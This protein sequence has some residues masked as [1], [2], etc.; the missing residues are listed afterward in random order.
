MGLGHQ[1]A[2]SI[3]SASGGL[4]GFFH[5]SLCNAADRHGI[6]SDEDTRWYLVQLLCNYASSGH[7]FDDA[8]EG[9]RLTPLAE[10]YRHAVEAGNEQ[11]RRLHLQRLGDVALVIAGL[12]SGVLRRKPVGVDYYI[13]MGGGAYGT[14]A[15]ADA[16]TTRDRA[17]AGIF[18]QLARSFEE[19]VVV[20]SDIP[21]ATEERSLV[22]QLDDWEATRHP[23]IARRLRERGVFV[24]DFD[25]AR[26]HGARH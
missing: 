10:H 11:L 3:I 18:A 9:V 4:Q 13:S 16:R 21:Q 5:D 20:L 25:A 23:A 14:L 22:Q 15:D 12:F 24:A 17:L 7:L 1:Q 8:G 26:D 6:D 19:W 2:S